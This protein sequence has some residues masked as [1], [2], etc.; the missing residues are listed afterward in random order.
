MGT[1][2]ENG[3]MANFQVMDGI[4]N[5]PDDFVKSSEVDSWTTLNKDISYKKFCQEVKIYRYVTLK[6]TCRIIFEEKRVQ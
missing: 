1:D 5:D 3:I 2:E 6:S 4:R